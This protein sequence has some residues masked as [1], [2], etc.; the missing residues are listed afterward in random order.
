MSHFTSP[1]LAAAAAPQEMAQGLGRV[2]RRIKKLQGQMQEQGEKV[3][4]VREYVNICAVLC[5]ASVCCAVERALTLTLPYPTLPYPIHS[6]PAK[7]TSMQLQEQLQL[8]IDRAANVR[9][10]KESTRESSSAAAAGVGAGVGVA[11]GVAAG[12]GAGEASG[13][14]TGTG[15]KA[16]KVGFALAPEEETADNKESNGGRESRLSSSGGRASVSDNSGYS[17]DIPPLAQ[18][19]I[20]RA[21][22]SKALANSLYWYLRVESDSDDTIGSLYSRVLLALIYKLA[23]FSRCVRVHASFACVIV[24]MHA[25][26]HVCMY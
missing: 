11:A 17:S 4:A 18:F 10:Q 1:R 24:C 6:P 23:S 16:V 22:T 8:A 14:G 12:A 2:Q 9:F 19:L 21:C 7:G 25:C 20:D 13:A 5:C 26:V 3:W 15:E